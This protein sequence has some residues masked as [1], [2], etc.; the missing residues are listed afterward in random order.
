MGI[1][2]CGRIGLCF[3]SITKGFGMK[4]LIYDVIKIK[5]EDLKERD[6]I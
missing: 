5:E 4:N 6:A 2:G 1:I 3:A